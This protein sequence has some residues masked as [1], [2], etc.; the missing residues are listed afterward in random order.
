[1][2]P[3][4]STPQTA[5]A[6]GEAE[7]PPVRNRGQALLILERQVMQQG[8]HL[9]PAPIPDQEGR[10]SLNDVAHLIGDAYGRFP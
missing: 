1:M 5:A 2:G 4:G 3:Q 10:K 8:A 9:V 6:P 7:G